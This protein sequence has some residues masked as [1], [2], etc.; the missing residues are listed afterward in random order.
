MKALL[1]QIA[2]LYAA[3]SAVHAPSGAFSSAGMILLRARRM[4]SAG[5]HGPCLPCTGLKR[6][7]RGKS[8][9]S[10]CRTSRPPMRSYVSDG[11]CRPHGSTAVADIKNL[12]QKT[13]G[14]IQTHPPLTPD[15]NDVV[16]RSCLEA[17][18]ATNR[19]WMNMRLAS[20]GAMK[21]GCRRA[22]SNERFLT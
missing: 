11:R 8:H 6:H 19:S 5:Q 18:A 20:E 16:I 14:S 22:D 3:D 13:P 21:G 2:A 17:A 12:C 4:S 10:R 9:L 7:A 15:R 1:T